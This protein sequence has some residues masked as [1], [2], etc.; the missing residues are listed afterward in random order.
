MRTIGVCVALL[1]L[2]PSV[3]GREPDAVEKELA[4]LQ[5]VWVCIEHLGKPPD[6]EIKL[7]I[8]KRGYQKVVKP[9][10]MNGI[11]TLGED[12]GSITIDPTKSPAQ[13]D[14]VGKNVTA[15][16]IYKLDGD[17]LVLLLSAKEKVRPESLEKPEKAWTTVFQREKK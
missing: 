17:K 13:I 1:F 7:V 6:G 12:E 9:A 10:A 16:G 3:G 2:P 8:E 15:L 5:G 11:A 4:K 14:L